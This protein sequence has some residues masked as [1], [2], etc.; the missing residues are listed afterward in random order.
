MWLLMTYGVGMNAPSYKAVV[1]L[2]LTLNTVP[3]VPDELVKGWMSV[4]LPPA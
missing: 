3:F 1:Q 2:G 4:Y